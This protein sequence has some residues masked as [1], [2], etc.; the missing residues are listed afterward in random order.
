[1]V[2]SS[3]K[4]GGKTTGGKDIQ[5]PPRPYTEYNFFFQLER[6][7]I[8]QNLGVIPA[9]PAEEV[10][11]ASDPNYDGPELHPR[12]HGLILPSDWYVPGKGRRKKRQ[13]VATHGKISFTNLSKSSTAA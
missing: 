5:P 12:Y 13:H 7:H 4:K 10:F 6:Q 2:A 1:M 8:L 3:L 9:L 11:L